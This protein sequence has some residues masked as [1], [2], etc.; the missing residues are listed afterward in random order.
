MLSDRRTVLLSLAAL[1]LAGCGFTPVYQQN[2][3]ARGLHGKIRINLI[4][5]R[6]GFQL[7]SRLE[8][9]LGSA[10]VNAPFAMTVDMAVSETDLILDV[11]LGITRYTL[12]GV[13]TISVKDVAADAV[14]LSGKLR[15]TVGY[16]GNAETAQTVAAKRDATDRLIDSLADMIVLR[17]TSTAESW[18]K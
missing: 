10:G 15:E 9:R 1:P 11:A 8:T 7:L 2:G 4:E 16:S 3:A 13:A 5:S 12:T 17:L 6:D 18:A 14:V